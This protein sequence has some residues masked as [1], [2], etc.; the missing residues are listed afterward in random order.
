MPE[1]PV[2]NRKS[3]NDE[4]LSSRAH[5]PQTSTMIPDSPSRLHPPAGVGRSSSNSAALQCGGKEKTLETQNQMPW[6]DA[7]VLYAPSSNVALLAPS[8][9][10]CDVG[11]E[12]LVD[13]RFN[14]P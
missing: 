5:S 14:W 3:I 9:L 11:L 2:D 10:S 13:F 7:G 4:R 8:P 1:D 6:S 12:K